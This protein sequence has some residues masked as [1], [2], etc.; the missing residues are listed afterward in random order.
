MRADL[1]EKMAVM[2][3]HDD[4]LLK[5]Q[6]EVFEPGNRLDVEMVGRFVEQQNVG[7]SKQRLRQ[8]DFHLFRA[9]QRAHLLIKIFRAQP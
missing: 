6:Q 4:G 9:G 7:I 8:Q 3:H 5:R 1:V 2:R